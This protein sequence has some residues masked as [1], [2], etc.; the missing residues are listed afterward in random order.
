MRIVGGIA[1][2][3]HGYPRATKDLDILVPREV[4]NA[5]RIVRSL[6]EFGFGSVGISE[7]DFLVP[8]QFI[9]LGRPPGRVHLLTS[10]QGVDW[11]EIAA[12]RITADFDGQPALVIGKSELIKAKKAAGR[13][14][15]LADVEGMTGEPQP[16]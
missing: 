5:A 2:G 3:L 1:V 16:D 11:A 4:Q 15:D 13:H 14:V 12:G 7:Q 6:D 9:I 10:L 8:G